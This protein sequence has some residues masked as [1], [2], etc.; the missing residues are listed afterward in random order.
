MTELEAKSKLVD[1]TDG[2]VLG[3]LMSEREKL[4]SLKES[5]K[6]RPRPFVWFIAAFLAIIFASYI[7]PKIAWDTSNLR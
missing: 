7:M 6:V 2:R 4:K 3:L 5:K 1:E